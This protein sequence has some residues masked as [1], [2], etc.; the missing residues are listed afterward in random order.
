MTE[1]SV[2][3]VL[4]N[5]AEG[6]EDA[7]NEWYD[8]THLADVLKVPGV[9]AAQRY[10]LAPMNSP[11][12]EGMGSPAHR[13]LATY[14]LDGDPDEVMAEFLRRIGAG[15]MTLSESLDMGTIV[16]TSWRPHGPRRT[17]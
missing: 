14:E 12:A 9:C 15:E 3:L 8:Q 16:M 1:N 7:Y 2:L 5:P 10:E 17:A 4:S 11:E 6:Q 13:Y